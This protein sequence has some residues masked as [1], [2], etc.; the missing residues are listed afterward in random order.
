MKFDMAHIHTIFESADDNKNSS[1]SKYADETGANLDNTLGDSDLIK[2]YDSMCPISGDVYASMKDAA[3][4]PKNLKLTMTKTEDF[5]EACQVYIEAVE[6]ATFCE[7]ADLNIGEAADEILEYVKDNVPGSVD[8]ELHV[9]FP[10]DSLNKNDLGSTRF[11]TD[12]KNDWAMQLMTG[13][14]RYGVS[15]NS[16]VEDGTTPVGTNE[17]VMEDNSTAKK[18]MKS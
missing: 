3:S 2:L 5:G 15:I 16:G 4:D 12:V 18:K 14:R 1:V 9:V 11:G 17:S 6:F 8:S 7:A 10:S 13:C